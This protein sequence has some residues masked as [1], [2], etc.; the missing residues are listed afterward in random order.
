MYWDISGVQQWL[1][2]S[3]TEDAGYE[4]WQHLM[5]EYA[6]GSNS[7]G[8]PKTNFWLAIGLPAND[9]SDKIKW[10]ESVP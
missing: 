1:V 8:L 5:K 7:A 6:M 10:H 3:G 2:S 9:Y 4:D